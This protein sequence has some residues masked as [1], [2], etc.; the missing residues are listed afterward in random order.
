MSGTTSIV[1]VGSD[2]V[3]IEQIYARQTPEQKIPITRQESARAPTLFIGD[4]ISDAPALV[5]AT[6]GLA[7]DHQS[8]ITTEA[9]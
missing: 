2:R 4:G 1:S 6:V 7:F 8:E 3:G 5:M 9:A